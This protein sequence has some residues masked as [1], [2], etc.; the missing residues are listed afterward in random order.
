[1]NKWILSWSLHTY[2]QL[3]LRIGFP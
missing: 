1:M 2:M 3:C